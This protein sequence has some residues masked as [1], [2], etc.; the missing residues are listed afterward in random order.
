MQ[1]PR[2]TRKQ[3]GARLRERGYPISDSTLNKLAAPAIGE[4]PPVNAWWNRRPLYDEDEGVAWA[5]ARLSS[6]RRLRSTTPDTET[7][8]LPPETIT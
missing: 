6:T 8:A 2:L 4:G 1:K 3:L 7:A 5:E